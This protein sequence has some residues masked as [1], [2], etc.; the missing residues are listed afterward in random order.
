MFD[1]LANYFQHK[2]WKDYKSYAEARNDGQSGTNNDL[3]LAIH[4][5]ESLYHLREHIPQIQQKSR[6]QIAKLCPDFNLLGDVFNAAKHKVL[7]QGNPKITN[8][9]DIYEQITLTRYEDEQGEYSYAKKLVLVSLNDGSIR[10]L[11]EILTNVLNFWLE[12]LHKLGVIE[13]RKP[14]KIENSTIPSREE[15]QLSLEITKGLSFKMRFQLL[16]YNYETKTTEPIDLTGK[17]VSFKIL[18]LPEEVD[19]ILTN[20]KN[21]EEIKRTIKLTEEQSRNIIKMTDEQTSEFLVGLAT[22]QGLFSN[23]SIENNV[24]N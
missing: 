14:I 22:E 20:N 1:D 6:N 2:V 7:T 8:A 16:K 19:I 23:P 4:A 5:A 24:D 18:P 13:Y 3:R 11:F 9:E 21:G 12:E 10:D 17:N 15:S